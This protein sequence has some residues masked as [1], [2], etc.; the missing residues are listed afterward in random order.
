V[1]LETVLIS[2]VLVGYLKSP[3]DSPEK[4]HKII[5]ERTILG[6]PLQS[7]PAQGETRP[8]LGD[9]WIRWDDTW[10]PPKTRI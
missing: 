7:G 10:E 3:F 9:L 4:K 2:V 5:I 1:Y 6:Y 8:F